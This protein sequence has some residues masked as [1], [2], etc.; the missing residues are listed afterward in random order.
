MFPTN[1]VNTATDNYDK[2]NFDL[3]LNTITTNNNDRRNGS[4]LHITSLY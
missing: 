1:A 3:R 4:D 2:D